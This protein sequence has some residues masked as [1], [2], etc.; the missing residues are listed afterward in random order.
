MGWKIEGL[1]HLH[2]SYSEAVKDAK[3]HSV[4]LDRIIEV[5]HV[6]SDSRLQQTIEDTLEQVVADNPELGKPTSRA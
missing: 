1:N 6:E 3:I 5:N 2:L 4:P